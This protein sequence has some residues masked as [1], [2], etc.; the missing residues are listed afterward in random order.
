MFE[1][2]VNVVFA[3]LTVLKRLFAPIEGNEFV[4]LRCIS[5]GLTVVLERLDRHRIPQS[6]FEL[7]VTGVYEIRNGEIVYWRE[8][9][10]LATIQNA[11]AELVG[12]SQ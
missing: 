9:F 4:I 10:D 3:T 12:D 5:G 7:P 6:W 8:Y 1:E 11:V 2:Y